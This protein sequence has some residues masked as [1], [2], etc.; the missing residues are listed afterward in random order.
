ML[1]VNSAT[2]ERA[3]LQDPRRIKAW[4]LN[5]EPFPA[6]ER[7]RVW[8]DAMR[9]ICLPVGECPEPDR[10][11]G[12]VHCLTSPL[13]VE[14]ALVEADALDISGGFPEQSPAIWLTLLLE[15]EA[16]VVSRG[17]NIQLAPG[18]IL[19][20]PTGVDATLR[21]PTPFRQLF[22]KA[23]RMTLNPRFIAPL[24]VELGHIP[25]KS[26]ISHV[27]SA[28]LR[29]L[30]SVMEEVRAAELGAV[31]IALT[32]F[33][34][35][36]LGTAQ[37]PA[38]SLGGTAGARAACLH[39]ICQ[40]IET[41]LGDPELTVAD[42]AHEHGVSPRYLQKLFAA[43]RPHV[44]QLR[45]HAPPG[46]LPVRP[47]EPALR[48][49]VDFRDLFSLGFQLLIALQSRVPGTIQDIPAAVSSFRLAARQERV[50]RD[51]SAH[52]LWHSRS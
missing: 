16:E 24:S 15:G 31:E 51:R 22:I 41:R 35:T 48:A 36:C 3:L 21:M 25:G 17:K 20:G 29:A 9:R 5:T 39:R 40:S 7:R 47:D 10:F 14:F 50:V 27:F 32:E 34:L 43:C 2:G 1:A 4:K 23:P 30:A 38:T 18:D 26:G 8:S 42:V 19:Y 11:R 44:Q 6:A 33:F 12:R 37:N 52:S 45:A 13:G 28:M 46:T 49:A